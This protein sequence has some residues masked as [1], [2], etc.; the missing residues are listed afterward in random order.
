MPPSA[1]ELVVILN[2]PCALST[3]FRAMASEFSFLFR[4]L[5]LV[6]PYCVWYHVAYVQNDLRA[7][8]SRKATDSTNTEGVEVCD[9]LNQISPVGIPQFCHV[10]VSLEI[11]QHNRSQSTFLYVR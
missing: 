4:F 3:S 5:L 9:E 10:A 1:L 6:H 7:V 11:L 2:C 8:H